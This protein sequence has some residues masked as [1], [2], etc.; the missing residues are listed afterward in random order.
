MQN[1][2]RVYNAGLAE[3]P[4]KVAMRFEHNSDGLSHF[5]SCERSRSPEE[6]A[7]TNFQLWLC[8]LLHYAS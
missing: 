1:G 5:A 6:R 8:R 3:L 7:H 2:L 4:S